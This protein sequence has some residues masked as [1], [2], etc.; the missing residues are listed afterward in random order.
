M[1]LYAHII[2]Q[3]DCACTLHCPDSAAWLLRKHCRPSHISPGQCW[4]VGT[5]VPVDAAGLLLSTLQVRLK[6]SA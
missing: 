2:L 4:Q 5:L 1:H 6:K 3:P